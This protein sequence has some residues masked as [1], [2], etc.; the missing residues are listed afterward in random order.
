[1]NLERYERLARLFKEKKYYVLLKDLSVW[2]N[3]CQYKPHTKKLSPVQK[4]DR[5]YVRL[6]ENNVRFE[7]EMH[8]LISV[9]C[10]IFVLDTRCNFIDGNRANYHPSNLYWSDSINLATRGEKHA[11]CKITDKQ[12]KE[13]RRAEIKAHDTRNKPLQELADKYGISYSYAALL[14]SKNCVFRKK[15]NL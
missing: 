12:V 11:R 2:S 13:I 6:T 5:R 15:K 4:G 9:W 14:R 7:Y 1:M 3:I 10:G 8:E